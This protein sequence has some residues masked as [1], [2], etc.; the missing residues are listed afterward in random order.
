M[1]TYTYSIFDADPNSTSG[2]VWPHHDRE[3]IEADSDAEAIAEV[4]SILA[5]ECDG[6]ST[7]DGYEVGQT[8]YAYV[9]AD[10]DTIIGYPTYEL[11][12]EDLRVAGKDHVSSWHQVTTYVATFPNDDSVGGA[13]DVSVEIGEGLDGKWYLRTQ[14]DA[15]GDDDCNDA[16]F[17][18][19]AAAVEAAEAFA[20][21]NNEADDD[22]D[23][24]AY[25]ERKRA[26]ERVEGYILIERMPDHLRESH[27][28][29]GNWGDYPHNGAER[30]LVHRDCAPDADDEYDR[31]IRDAKPGDDE[32]YTIERY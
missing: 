13:T 28:K 7:R 27:R 22:E 12:A 10:G 32:R 19:R 1:A 20:E 14:D 2:T 30:V 17:D 25:I 4:E 23:S 8:I 24:D 21:E 6:L 16:G 11:T 9:W 26:E 29:A 18:S 31:V 3:E 15:G 5:S